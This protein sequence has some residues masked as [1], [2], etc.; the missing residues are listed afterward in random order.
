MSDPH[1]FLA[2]TETANPTLRV[3]PGAGNSTAFAGTALIGVPPPL[4]SITMSAESHQH[5]QSREQPLLTVEAIT[6][7]TI[8]VFYF[9]LDLLRRRERPPRIPGS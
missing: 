6:I 7:A 5:D 8:I 9:V 1:F 2:F 4:Q 3:P